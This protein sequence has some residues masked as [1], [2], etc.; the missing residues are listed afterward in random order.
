VS[1]ETV[2][3]AA[4]QAARVAAARRALELGR[5]EI[6]PAG[7]GWEAS[8]GHVEA[9]AVTV[10][11]DAFSLGR[12][13]ADPFARDDLERALSIGIAKLPSASM[14][15]LHTR[16]GLV[17]SEAPFRDAPFERVAELDAPTIARA[18]AGYLGGLGE[19]G[20]EA[21]LERL[22]LRVDRRTVRAR[23]AG[24]PPSLRDRV[25]TALERLAGPRL[26]VRVARG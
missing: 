24:G 26:R 17:E 6:E 10:L 13:D 19:A 1:E 2:R 21:T 9:L 25:A 5:L 16:F 3:L 23:L 4:V 15:E 7:P 12:L 14:T 20:A 11:T 18:L 8:H 22:E